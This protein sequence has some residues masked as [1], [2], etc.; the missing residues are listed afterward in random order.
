MN[1]RCTASAN[2]SHAD[3]I[4]DVSLAVTCSM[5]SHFTSDDDV[6]KQSVF[7]QCHEKN[8]EQIS[9]TPLNVPSGF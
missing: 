2:V 1:I 3:S 8:A 7:L 5:L 9:E 6:V 4:M